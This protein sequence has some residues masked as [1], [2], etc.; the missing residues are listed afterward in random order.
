LSFE[1]ERI[2]LLFIWGRAK[3]WLFEEE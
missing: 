3:Q 2:W 1:E